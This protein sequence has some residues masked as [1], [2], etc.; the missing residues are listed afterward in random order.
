MMN[1]NQIRTALEAAA[2]AHGFELVASDLRRGLFFVRKGTEVRSLGSGALYRNMP[3][4]MID[5]VVALTVREGNRIDTIKGSR[6][7]A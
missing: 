2:Q 7:F 4:E 5:G 1:A 3:A 6:Y